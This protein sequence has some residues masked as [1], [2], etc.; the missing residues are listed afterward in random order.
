ME[1][2]RRFR[3]GIS[4]QHRAS[5]AHGRAMQGQRHADPVRCL[6]RAGFTRDA[7]CSTLARH[8]PS[9]QISSQSRY[10]SHTNFLNRFEEVA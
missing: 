10:N 5:V 2:R 9:G 3:K 6:H 4:M 8:A 7:A 1:Q